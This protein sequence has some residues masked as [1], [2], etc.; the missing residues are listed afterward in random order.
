MIYLTCTT[1]DEH[2]RRH[3]DIAACEDDDHAQT[4][5]AAGWQRVSY[6]AFRAAWRA[7][8]AARY[9]SLGLMA[10]NTA[11]AS[12]PI[13]RVVGDPALPPGWVL[14]SRWED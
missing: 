10:Q 4:Y 8:D 3:I 13:E 14:P 6:D 9:E 11:Q 1:Y 5:I 7:R 12:T 2:D